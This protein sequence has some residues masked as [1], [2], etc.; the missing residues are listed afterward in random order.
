[1]QRNTYTP[2]FKQQIIK[3]AIE[4]GNCTI[5]AR[6]YDVNPNVLAR[7][8]RE[9]KNNG[10]ISSSVTNPDNRQVEVENEK[11]K[12]LLGEKELENQILRDLIKKS[13]PHLLKKLK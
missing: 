4:T 11:L 12:K 5:V 8:V 10:S 13:N 3:E 1:M 7:W 6:R 2:E 9:Y